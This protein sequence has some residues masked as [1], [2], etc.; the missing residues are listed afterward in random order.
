MEGRC[1]TNTDLVVSG[2]APQSYGSTGAKAEA[3]VM[4]E[5]LTESCN[6]KLE[7]IILE[8]TAYHTLD[9]F[10]ASKA[11]INGLFTFNFISGDNV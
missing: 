4:K 9:N 5:Y 8:P 11:R 3:L 10:I 1:D 2:G 7:H 6:V